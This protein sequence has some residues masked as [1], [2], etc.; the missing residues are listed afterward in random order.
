MSSA[1]GKLVDN[2]SKIK[3]SDKEKYE[4]IDNMRSTARSLQ[5]S[6]NNY[7]DLNK[8][9]TDIFTS[10]M[11]ANATSL[12]RHIDRYEE[13]CNKMKMRDLKERFPNT[14]QLCDDDLN[15]FML[16]LRKGVYPYQYTD[17]WEKFNKTSLP[18]IEEFYDP[19][20]MEDISK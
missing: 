16:L 12:L 11:R 3:D 7:S 1:L 17:S 15:K 14:Y 4:F 6:I 19:F 2:L 20:N 13:I 18:T 10:N 9:E 5:S 8:N